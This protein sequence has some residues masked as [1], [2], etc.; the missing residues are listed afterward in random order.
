LS[1]FEDEFNSLLP[2]TKTEARPHLERLK[3]KHSN[4]AHLV[5][6]DHILTQLDDP[7]KRIRFTLPDA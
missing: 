5:D 3:G 7:V 6:V 2:M 1:A 4:I